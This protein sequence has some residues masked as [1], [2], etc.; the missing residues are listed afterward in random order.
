MI[1]QRHHL[2]DR[3]IIKY[4]KKIWLKN[5]LRVEIYCRVLFQT[6]LWGDIRL[7]FWL[8]FSCCLL[9]KRKRRTGERKRTHHSEI[10]L[11]WWR[12]H[13]LLSIH[14][15]LPHLPVNSTLK[16]QNPEVSEWDWCHPHLWA[17]TCLIQIHT[18]HPFSYKDWLT[19]RRVTHQTWAVEKEQNNKIK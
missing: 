7:E 17:L 13:Q 4:Q 12:L 8:T 3:K 9:S 15:C 14:P 1:F 19:H 10:Q 16:N 6:L 18:F 11:G 5:V 2:K